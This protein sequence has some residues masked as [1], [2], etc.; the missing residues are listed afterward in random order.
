MLTPKITLVSPICSHQ[1][2]SPRDV[3]PDGHLVASALLAMASS[4]PKKF[5]TL[6]D[7]VLRYDGSRTTSPCHQGDEKGSSLS[8]LRTA[9]RDTLDFYGPCGLPDRRVDLPSVLLLL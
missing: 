8:D 7:R 6:S 1:G 2:D 4:D 5:Y 3:C 9:H